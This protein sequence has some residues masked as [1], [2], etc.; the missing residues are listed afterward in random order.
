MRVIRGGDF[1]NYASSMLPTFRDNSSPEG[2]AFNIGF[3][4]A[5]SL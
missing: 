5:R 1:G 4:C 3:R 2:R